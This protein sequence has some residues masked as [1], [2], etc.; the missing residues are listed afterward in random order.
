MWWKL[1]TGGRGQNALGLPRR[2][3]IHWRHRPGS[4]FLKEVQI[5]TNLRICALSFQPPLE[6]Q[7]AMLT[8]AWRFNTCRLSSV[9]ARIR[10]VYNICMFLLFENAAK[11]CSQLVYER[12]NS[13]WLW[14]QFVEYRT[15]HSGW[16]ACISKHVPLHPA[17]K[18][19]WGRFKS[20]QA[21]VWINVNRAMRTSNTLLALYCGRRKKFSWANECMCWF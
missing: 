4:T 19:G 8:S 15:Q 11:S 14:S 5:R 20:W 10:N 12:S 17:Y 2:A 1:L 3:I 13:V 16:T 18:C 9:P 6:L 7:D 21:V